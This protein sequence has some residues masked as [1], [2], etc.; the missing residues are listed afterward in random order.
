MKKPQAL[1][2]RLIESPMLAIEPGGCPASA[3]LATVAGRRAVARPRVRASRPGRTSLMVG[4]SFVRGARGYRRVTSCDTAHNRT[5]TYLNWKKAKGVAYSRPGL[6]FT[7]IGYRFDK[8]TTAPKESRPC[9]RRC[10]HYHRR[11]G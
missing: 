9:P 2:P 4:A 10:P 8:V 5:S 1:N 11:S 6:P 3:A 7:G